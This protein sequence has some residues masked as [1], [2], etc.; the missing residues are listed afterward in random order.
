[1]SWQVR[2]RFRVFARGTSLRRRVAYSLA[3]V[4]LILVPVIFLA[5]YYLFAMGWIVDRIVSVDAPMTSCAERVSVE[6]LDARR[7]ERNYFLLHDP[8]ELQANRKLLAD[9]GRTLDTC[10]ELQPEEQEAIDKIRAQAGIYQGR[11][12]EA[13]ARM[14]QPAEAPVGHLQEVVRAYERD[15][16]ELLRRGKRQSRAQLTQE[17]Q[18]RIGSLDAEIAGTLVAGDPAFRRITADLQAS[19]REVM[20]LASELE[21]RGWERVQ[22]DHERAR[23]LV[24]RAEWV[25][26]IVSALTLLLSVWV[27]FFLPREAVRP[28]AD[29]K[30][31]VDHAASGNYEI[32][33]EV[34]GDGEIAQLARSVRDLIAHV[35]EKETSYRKT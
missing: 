31:A 19:S 26:G 3:G 33:F 6:M 25:L 22:R 13:V 5:I 27:S 9:L 4:R 17:L 28:L 16:N 20:R 7:A 14:G 15:L 12:N 2:K 8:A 24:R 34:Q 21:K 18:S 32:D 11:V 35:R 23:G 1:M 10:R 29:L 30:A